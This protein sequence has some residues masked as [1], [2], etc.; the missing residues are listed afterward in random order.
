MRMSASQAVPALTSVFGSDNDVDVRLAAVRAL[1][2]FPGEASVTALAPALRNADPA[3]Q[4]RATEALAQVTG[5]SFGPD[6]QAWSRYV[7]QTVGQEAA[8]EPVRQA[9]QNPSGN[10]SRR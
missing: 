3:I 8:E 10:T 6:V 1:G 9:A 2:A 5:E 4:L 7:S